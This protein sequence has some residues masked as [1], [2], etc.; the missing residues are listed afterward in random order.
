L[1]H[2]E[3]NLEKDIFNCY[4]VYR[5]KF[6]NNKI[7]TFAFYIFEEKNEEENPH[8]RKNGH[9]MNYEIFIIIVFF[10]KNTLVSIGIC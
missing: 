3:A 6:V 2:K 7:F 10:S 8:K 5:V 9:F 1:F 4:I